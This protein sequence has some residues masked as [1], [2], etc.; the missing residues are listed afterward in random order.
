M[1]GVVL[2]LEVVDCG[3]AGCLGLLDYMFR[4]TEVVAIQAT[5]RVSGG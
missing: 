5:G 4:D 1:V 3:D 2:I